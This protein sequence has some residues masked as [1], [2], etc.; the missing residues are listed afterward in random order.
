M[1]RLEKGQRVSFIGDP[2]KGNK[3]KGTVMQ[4]VD[5]IGQYEIHTDRGSVI[6]L[7]ETDSQGNKVLELVGG[8]AKDDDKD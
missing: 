4:H 7:P 6:H 8:R 5:R 2:A 1:P 3:E